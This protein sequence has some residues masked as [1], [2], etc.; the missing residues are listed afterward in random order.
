MRIAVVHGYFLNDSGSGTYARELSRALVNEGH[1]VTLICQERRP[2]DFD[3]INSF[4]EFS[5]D[6]EELKKVF[7]RETKYKGF[8]RLVRPSLDGELL[9]FVAGDFEG[10]TSKTFQEA[11]KS[12]IDDYIQANIKGVAKIFEKWP[13]DLVQANHVIMQPYIAIRALSKGTPVV[14]S[15]QGSALNFSVKKDPRL[16]PYALKGL[17]ESSAIAVQSSLSYKDIVGFAKI[18]GLDV[19]RKTQKI[20]P[21]VDGNIFYPSPKPRQKIVNIDDFRV[22][23][24]DNVLV[25]AGALIWTKGIH[26]LIASLPLMLR[27]RPNIK[28]IIAGSGFQENALKKLISALDNG[29]FEDANRLI[30]QEKYLGSS[31]D[32]GPVIPKMN[33]IKRKNYIEAATNNLKKRI[34]FAG[35][36]SHSR[37]AEL[38]R[39][40]DLQVV[41]SIAPEAFGLVSTEA[42]S[43]GLLPVVTYQ[44][45]LRSVIDAIEGSFDEPLLKALV[46]GVNLTEKLADV[47]LKLLAK[48][49]TKDP[50]FK[51]ELHKIAKKNFSWSYAAQMIARINQSKAA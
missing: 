7:S 41:T 23:K 1:D 4:F 15:I 29:R 11:S 49:K 3:F 43:S 32:Y 35:H 2:S 47:C 17:S 21:G 24:Q 44:S 30:E 45:G 22:E 50:R 27:E 16:V 26:Y 13:Q 46:P 6:N 51:N 28:L 25:Y 42:L 14:V 37:L 8:C 33:D 34:Y 5:K 20:M 9:T 36:V 19:S 10:F 18:Y 40:A 38:Q 12:E 39:P 48:Y 31:K